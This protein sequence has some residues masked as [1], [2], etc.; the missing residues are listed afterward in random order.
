V[1]RYSAKADWP[2]YYCTAAACTYKQLHA[3]ARESIVTCSYA[4]AASASAGASN[5]DLDEYGINC[6]S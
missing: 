4:S 1:H 3:L 2:W 5:S 6:K